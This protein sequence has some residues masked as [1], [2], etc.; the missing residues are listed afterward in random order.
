MTT[1]TRRGRKFVLVPVEAW[2]RLRTGRVP[3][4]ELPE[5]DADGNN[6]GEA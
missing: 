4:P 5:A 3:M 2:E 6:S 1:L